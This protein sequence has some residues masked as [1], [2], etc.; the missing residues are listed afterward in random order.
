VIDQDIGGIYMIGMKRVMMAGLII[1][2]SM[3]WGPA[4]SFSQAGIPQQLNL[5]ALLQK[6]GEHCRA[7]NTKGMQGMVEQ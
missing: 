5:A 6:A 2:L 3:A 7:Q 4:A 1:G